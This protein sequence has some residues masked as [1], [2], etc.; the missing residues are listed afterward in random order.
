MPP[1]VNTQLLD[2]LSRALLTAVY[3][4]DGQTTH[5]TGPDA[6]FHLRRDS[7]YIRIIYALTKNDEWFRRLIRDGHDKRCMSLVDGVYQSHY[8]PIGF[9]LLVIF[10]RIKSSGKDLP[11]SLVQEKW[12]LLIRNAW[13]RATYNE[14]RDI[15]DVNG[16]PAFVTATRLN[17][18]ASDN[19]VPRKWFTDLAAKV[20]E[21]L[22]ILQRRQATFRVRVVNNSIGQ[23]AVDTAVSSIQG[24]HDELGCV[25]EQ[26]N[27][28][29]RDDKVSGS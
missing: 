20:H 3:P 7:C 2:E 14:I 8:S 19:E 28:S 24:L 13:D 21:V 22:V 6:S 12:R 9:Y 11:F 15:N 26:R 5:D 17:L 23:A 16:I 29:Q 27:A 4:K 1:G 10:G 25:V 18:S